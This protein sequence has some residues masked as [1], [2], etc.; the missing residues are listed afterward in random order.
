MFSWIAV[1]WSQNKTLL[2]KEVKHIPVTYIEMETTLEMFGDL[3]DVV[4]GAMHPILENFCC[5]WNECMCM[6]KWLAYLINTAWVLKPLHIMRHIQLELFHW[7]DSTRHG[8]DP[9][10]LALVGIAQEI[11]WAVFIAPRMLPQGFQH[12]E[13]GTTSYAIATTHKWWKRG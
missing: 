3:A 2:A 6:K 7:I 8:M 13:Q 4:L 9:Q 12:P 5:F 10:P 11:V 1:M